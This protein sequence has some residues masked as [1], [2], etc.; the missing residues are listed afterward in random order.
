MALSTNTTQFMRICILMYIKLGTLLNF[1][2][3]QMLKKS[4]EIGK[5]VCMYE[6]ALLSGVTSLASGKF[7]VNRLVHQIL[8]YYVFIP[9]VF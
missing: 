5:A 1:L 3:V 7:F 6:S 9:F 4:P 2:V 8:F